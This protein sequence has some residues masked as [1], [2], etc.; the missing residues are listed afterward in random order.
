MDFL[1]DFKSYLLL[2]RNLSINT[3]HNYE[4]DIKQFM[5]YISK[6]LE[7]VTSD[8]I[9]KFIITIR[10]E[11]RSVS[12]ANR[13]LSTIKSFYKFLIRQGVCKTN[14]A[15]RIDSGKREQRLPKPADIEDIEKLIKTADNLRD[16]LIFELLFATGLRREELCNISINDVN[17][18]DGYIRVFGKG[19]KERIVPCH[20]TALKMITDLFNKHNSKWLFP[21]RKNKGHHIHVHTV[22]DIFKK[23]VA[24]A[25]LEGKNITP[26][27]LRHSFATYL[28]NNGADILVI[29]KLLGHS[30]VSTTQIYTQ[31][32]SELSMKEYMK[33]HPKANKAKD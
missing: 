6:P 19:G 4:L 24:K 33:Y 7:E 14:P 30:S 29:Q 22:N 8:D 15:D 20:P 21:S 27:K 28:H 32:S 5:N 10:K 9:S 25:G 3:V 26:H 13:K 2:E 23:W 1:E 11:G 17:F 12:T 16:K 31:V 18:N